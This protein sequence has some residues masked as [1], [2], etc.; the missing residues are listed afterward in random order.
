MADPASYRIVIQGELSDKWVDWFEGL[1]LL[2]TNGDSTEP[3]TTLAGP[4]RDQAAL[5]GILERLW[6]LNL[7][8]LL[9]ERST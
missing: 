5:R 1:S 7:T 8:V 2:V 3:V 6:D 9:V 4:I